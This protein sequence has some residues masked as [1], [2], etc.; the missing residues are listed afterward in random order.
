MLT[1]KTLVYVERFAEVSIGDTAADLDGSG[2]IY[3][4]VSEVAGIL[5]MKKCL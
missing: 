5:P 3:S 4:L 1:A 2:D